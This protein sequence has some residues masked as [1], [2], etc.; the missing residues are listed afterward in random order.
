MR[1]RRRAAEKSLA[2]SL[3]LAHPALSDPNFRRT[4]ILMTEDSGEGS[5][6]V[7]LNRPLGKN[8]GSLGGEFA[9]GSLAGVPA[10]RGGPVHP[11]QLILAAWTVQAHGFNL[12]FGIEPDKA[13][14][15]LSVEGTHIRAFFGYSGWSAG[16]LKNELK[17]QTWVVTAPPEDLFSQPSD[18]K[19]WGTVLGREGDQWRLLAGEPE[20]PGAN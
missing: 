8:L 3:L 20:E 4:V 2:G 19:L 5:M 7:V 16:Q 6:G 9:L 17:H 13:D 1:E 12:H 11:E 18:A 10:F 14:Q 15:F